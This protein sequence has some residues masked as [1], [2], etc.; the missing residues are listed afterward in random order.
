MSQ[1]PRQAVITKLIAEH[2]AEIEAIRT[3]LATNF[4]A[5]AQ[6][7]INAGMERMGVQRFLP[8]GDDVW[9]MISCQLNGWDYEKPPAQVMAR[10]ARY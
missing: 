9:E 7:I 3:Q 2:S 4:D 6:R 8:T 1:T 10:W 5:P